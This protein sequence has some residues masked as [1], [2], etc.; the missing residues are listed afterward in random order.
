MNVYGVIVNKDGEHGKIHRG[1][2]VRMHNFI[3]ITG[4]SLEPD[5]SRTLIKNR[6]P[7]DETLINTFDTEHNTY[8][9]SEITPLMSAGGYRRHCLMDLH[10]MLGNVLAN[11]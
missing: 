6:E 4:N 7:S 9:M 3:M 2:D 8:V 1:G 5:V 11:T 10:I